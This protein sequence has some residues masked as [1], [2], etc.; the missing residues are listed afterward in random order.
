M[1]CLLLQT[2]GFECVHEVC[3]LL[4]CFMSSMICF[5]VSIK[6]PNK[7]ERKCSGKCDVFREERNTNE[8]KIIHSRSSTKERKALLPCK[9][10]YT[11]FSH[12]RQAW[13]TLHRMKTLVHFAMVEPEQDRADPQLRHLHPSTRAVWTVGSCVKWM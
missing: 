2:L 10:F 3:I 8:V 12:R 11:S 13:W 1:R 9:I 4:K 7:I 6:P 5:L